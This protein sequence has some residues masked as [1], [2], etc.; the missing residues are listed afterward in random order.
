MNSGSAAPVQAGMVKETAWT[1]DTVHRVEVG[2]EK[3]EGHF[4]HIVVIVARGVLVE[5]TDKPPPDALWWDE[6]EGVAMVPDVPLPDGF[7]LYDEPQVGATF[8]AGDALLRMADG[9]QAT[10]ATVLDVH[11]SDEVNG[12][13]PGATI[14]ILVSSPA[15][16]ENLSHGLRAAF[17]PA[18]FLGEPEDD[19]MYFAGP[20]IRC[21]KCDGRIAEISLERSEHRCED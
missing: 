10:Q 18:H 7:A 21:A 17:D 6:S 9:T 4:L 12:W 13:M 19:E 11:D 3:F 1:A 8:G 2:V 15:Q 5:W 20:Y 14:T 16:V